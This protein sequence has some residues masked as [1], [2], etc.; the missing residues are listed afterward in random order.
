MT[1]NKL[2]LLTGLMLVA[3]YSYLYWVLFQNPHTH[4]NATVCLFKNITGIPCPGC[5]STRAVLQLT[6]G[7]FSHA[8]LI[9]PIGYIIAFFM[10]ILPFWIVYD[11][12]AQKDTF[13]KAY[14]K[15]ERLLSIKWV[16]AVFIILIA[17]N[18]IW[19]IYKVN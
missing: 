11:I 6:Q 9:N 13:L 16:L 19:N 8:A 10:L 17:A 1:K 7:H 3:G 2:Y 18:W 15:T 12:I 4:E 5:G 14:K